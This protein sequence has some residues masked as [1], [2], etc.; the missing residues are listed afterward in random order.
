MRRPRSTSN[1]GAKNPS[2]R[3]AYTTKMIK[4]A[5]LLLAASLSV[6]AADKVTVIRAARMFDGKSDR[7]VSPGI[8]VVT[9]TK[10]TAAGPPAVAPA[11]AQGIALGDGTPLPALRDRP[12]H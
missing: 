1:P 2:R 6:A 4:F 11:G 3:V 9:G 5:G 8:L 12:T 7:V 10:I